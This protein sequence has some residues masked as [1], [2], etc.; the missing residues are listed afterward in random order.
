MSHRKGIH[1]ITA[2]AGDPQQNLD[3]YSGLL[4]LRLVKKTVNFDDPSVYHLY[5]GDASGSPG[6]ILTFFP[7]TQLQQGEPDRGQAI[8]I[9]FSIPT[10]SISFWTDYFNKKDIRYMDPF[11]RFGKKVIG[12][13]DPDGL[14]LELIADPAADKAD[15]WNNGPVPAEHTI[16]GFHGVTLAEDNY[17]STGQLLIESLGFEEVDQEHDRILYRSD[18]QFGSTVE[19]IDNAQLDGRPGKGT[20]H[21]VAFRAKDK[22]EQLAIRKD[23]VDIGY[24]VTDVKDRQYF[25]SIYFHEP[26]GVLFEVATDPPGFTTDES[27][28]SLGQKLQLPPWLESKRDLIEADL[29]TLDY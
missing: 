10:D 18:S 15:G 17:Q 26:G 5:Y 13:Q 6:S 27:L 20:V 25:E 1:H 22:D 12:L 28:D 7:W 24:H 23:L 3:F 29:I 8:A 14:H 2:V 11:E 19:I 4:G 9:S 16:R 21:H